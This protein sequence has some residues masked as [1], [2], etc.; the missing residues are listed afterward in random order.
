LWEGCL[1]GSQNQH[2]WTHPPASS[3]VA[4][5]LHF[6]PAR[7]TST[8]PRR[9]TDTLGTSLSKTGVLITTQLLFL[10][11]FLYT[12]FRLPPCH[13]LE[14]QQDKKEEVV[15]GLIWLKHEIHIW[16]TEAKPPWTINIHF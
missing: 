11:L 13:C 15:E 8:A 1:A 7:C 12:F 2:P 16:N 6:P 5:G 3:T 4:S 14:T 9:V 10:C